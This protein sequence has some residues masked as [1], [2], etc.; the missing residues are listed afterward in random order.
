[1]AYKGKFNHQRNGN[2]DPFIDVENT[3]FADLDLGLDIDLSFLD[4]APAKQA[5]A[6]EAAPAE[7]PAAAVKP[8]KKAEKAAMK[9]AKE[10]EKAAAKAAKEAAKAEKKAEAKA[11]REEKK[12][13]AKPVREEKKPEVKPVREE[14]KFEKKPV[15]KEIPAEA[16]PVK[17][18][19][20]ESAA[21]KEAPVRKAP[22]AP[23]DGA[24]MDAA[25]MEAAKKAA[26]LK[27]QAAAAAANAET[28]KAA[29]K[30]PAKKAAA[31]PVKKAAP[32]AA[33]K[34][35]APVEPPK[36]K[37]KGPR[38]GGVIFYTLYF[39][40]ILVFFI[41]TYIGLQWLHGWLA[42]Y[43]QSQPVYK[44][45]A[46]FQ[47]LFTD[48]DWG[49]LY[50]AAGAQ[51]SL[52]EGKEEYV[53]YMEAKVDGQKLN[54]MET[55]AGLSGGKKYVVR[56]GEEKVASFTLKD[57]KGV[58]TPSLS[59]L[60]NLGEIPDWQLSS[61]EVFFVREGSYRIEKVDGC[62]VYVNDVALDDSYTIQIATTMAEEL[63]PEGTTGASMCLQ[64]VNGIMELPTVKILDKEG[65]E[66]EVTYDEAT[67]T[68]TQRTE[69]NTMSEEQKTVA[70]EASKVNCLWMIEE[71]KDRGD[72]AKYYD[73]ASKPYSDITKLG[74]LWM[75]GHAGYE[76]ANEEVSKFASYGDD[77]FS[78]FV[79][80][81]LNVTRKD[82][83]V[84]TYE[85]D[86][87]LFFKNMKGTWKV[88][89]WTNVD[90]SQPVG[91]VR[92]TFM[93]GD[94]LLTS[95][96]YTTDAKEVITPIMPAPAGKVLSGWA[97][98]S[99]EDGNTVYT[100]IFAPDETGRVALAEGTTLTPMTLYAVFEDADA[101]EAAPVE[102]AP[103]ETEEGA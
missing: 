35:A 39:M 5:P 2:A 92:L 61:V 58:G 21:V 102:T 86:K 91:K 12:A 62:T 47:Q 1:M 15:V 55:S 29:P 83:S 56:L 63:L 30:A 72:V 90:V 41:G 59:N 16:A 78:V 4:E 99:E 46:V 44:A 77:L 49:A 34:A 10:A 103:A 23:A 17:Q 18:A 101:V 81:D 69:S 65:N 70:L 53:N 51:D 50:E 75:Q 25:R 36:K 6:P 37:K 85:F 24:K 100:L 38:L 45:E 84:K 93:D 60:E 82:G 68:F 74:E 89:D 8:D 80:M 3:S 94:T 20:A 14:K 97:T 76:F 96:F 57:T 27:R 64:Q 67:R 32:E 13:E 87:T 88:I 43:E 98:I 52:Y 9:A 31:A 73:N 48:P 26:L 7:A 71:I 33:K 28:V 66:M 22:K 54:Y 79:S 95:D 11:A 42:D 19:P 40:F